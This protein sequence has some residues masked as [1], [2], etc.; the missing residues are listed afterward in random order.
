MG[1]G[2]RSV[3][4]ENQFSQR[5][6]RRVKKLY[7]NFRN[8]DTSQYSM[9]AD[10][11]VTATTI[12]SSFTGM[13]GECTAP[14]LQK[15][16]LRLNLHQERPCPSCITI[17]MQNNNKR[18]PIKLVSAICGLF[19]QFCDPSPG[20]LDSI[21]SFRYSTTIVFYRFFTWHQHANWVRQIKTQQTG[22]KNERR[23]LRLR[24]RPR[25][26]PDFDSLRTH[27]PIFNSPFFPLSLLRFRI[28]FNWF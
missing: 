22:L 10:W 21:Q 5:K 17:P 6:K 28:Y 24:C 2:R 1:W 25:P 14:T 26:G 18:M 11:I 19:P 4:N 3:N 9:C 8:S 23:I 27:Q 16:W 7:K 15:P 13:S 20:R 12:Y